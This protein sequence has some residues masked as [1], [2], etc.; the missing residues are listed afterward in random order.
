MNYNKITA[1][2]KNLTTIGYTMIFGILIS[3]IQFIVMTKVK[4]T[5]IETVSKISIFFTV[6]YIVFTINIISNLLSAGSNLSSFGDSAFLADFI[7]I[8]TTIGNLQVAQHDFPNRMTLEDAK[9]ACTK[10]GEGWRLPTFD[11]LRLLFQN[12]DKVS[13]FATTSY[14]SSTKDAN[15]FSW[16]EYIDGGIMGQDNFGTKSYTYGVR[17]VR[18]L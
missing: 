9:A 7:G 4:I 13:G 3:V 11:E 5:D 1:A 10:L 18:S 17:A 8:P 2:G 14:W 15:G 6:L 16:V 12:K